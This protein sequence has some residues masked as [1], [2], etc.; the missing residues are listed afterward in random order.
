[1]ITILTPTYNRAYTLERLYESLLL[2]NVPFEWLIVDDGS[3]DTTHNLI[4]SWQKKAPFAIHYTYQNNGGKHVAINTGVH[5]AQGEFIFIVDSD[6]ALTYDAL[7]T[8]QYAINALDNT[9]SGLCFRK[10]LFNG[11][12]IGNSYFT[13][14]PISLSP[15][16]ASNL[17]QGD[18]AYIFRTKMLIAYPFPTIYRETFVPELLIWNRIADSGEVVYYPTTAIYQC[19]YLADGYSANFKQNLRKNPKGFAL[20]YRDQF[21]REKSLIQKL[22]CAVRYVQCL[23]Y[24]TFR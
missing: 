12:M 23:Y 11:N 3:T 14:E 13:S 4:T 21:F 9:K 1:M 17:F 7:A 2:Q 24:G 8:V 18:L 19:E 15:T 16:E 5:K 20:F 6:D 10:L 22:K